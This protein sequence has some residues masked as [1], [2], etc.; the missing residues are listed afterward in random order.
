MRH[1]VTCKN[2]IKGKTS[3]CGVTA[4][5]VFFLAF[6]ISDTEFYSN[7]LAMNL[8]FRGF[9]STPDVPTTKFQDGYRVKERF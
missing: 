1:Q 2:L 6:M 7:F 4:A 3:G 8:G 9:G 5:H